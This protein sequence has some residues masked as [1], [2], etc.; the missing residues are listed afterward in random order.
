M[1]CY[2]Q[3]SAI[4]FF[5][6]HVHFKQACAASQNIQFMLN[7]IDLTPSDTQNVQIL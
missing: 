3:A 7:S 5:Q 4:K 1:F 6:T 2:A